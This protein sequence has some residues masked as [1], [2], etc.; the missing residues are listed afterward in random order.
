MG[1]DSKAVG[2]L[3]EPVHFRALLAD[4]Q[5]PQQLNSA[6]HVCGFRD[7]HT[8]ENWVASKL[9][10]DHWRYTLEPLYAEG[11][12][13]ALMA[14]RDAL[15]RELDVWGD[16]LPKAQAEIAALRLE[17]EGLR[18][19]PPDAREGREPLTDERIVSLRKAARS[20]SVVKPWG[21]TIAFARA[22]EAAHRIGPAGTSAEGAQP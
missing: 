19:I 5:R 4:D 2:A 3:P 20:V 15:R 6:M 12:M 9:D 1:D 14:E 16:D 18:A 13:R 17:L 7:R 22:I 8:A 21:D 11:D 10:F